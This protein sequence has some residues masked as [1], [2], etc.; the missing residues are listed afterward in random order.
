LKVIK[1]FYEN[2]MGNLPN[3]NYGDGRSMD[4]EGRFR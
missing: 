3:E 4:N 2:I 1:I